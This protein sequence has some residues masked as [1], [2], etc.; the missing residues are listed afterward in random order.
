MNNRYRIVFMGTP[1]FAAESL[2]VLCEK[3]YHPVAVYTQPDKVNKR[4]KRVIF[5]PVKELALKQNIPVYQPLG[6]NEEDTIQELKQLQPDIIIVIAYG[7]ILPQAVL[8]IPK[9]GAI[10]VHASILPEYRGAAP[11]QRA[12]IDGKDKTGITVMKLD[13]GMDTGDIITVAE[14]KIEKH[15]TAGELFSKLAVLGAEKLLQVLGDLPNMISK[16]VPQNHKEATYAEKITKEMGRIDWTKSACTLDSLIRG[17]YPNPGTYTFFRGKRIKIHRAFFR[18]LN[19][20]A[21][22]PGEVISIKD[23]SIGIA[24]SSGVIYITGLQPENHKLMSA[25]DF[26]NGYQVKE[27]DRFDS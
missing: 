5:S 19:S 2:K 11:I 7:K 9:Y 14:T 23:G 12:I 16:A 25:T 21:H 17:M 1:A 13:S 20:S 26:I 22:A 27:N 10:N 18:H 4:G 8:G 3:E 24:T 6:F 15:V